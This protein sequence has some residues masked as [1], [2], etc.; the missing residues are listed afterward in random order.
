MTQTFTVTNEIYN[1]KYQT[2]VRSTS[3][4]YR[5]K[6]ELGRIFHQLADVGK[7]FFTKKEI[8][9]ILEQAYSFGGSKNP[10]AKANRVWG[11]Y[12][13]PNKDM[14]FVPAI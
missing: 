12:A 13:K 5:A 6:P 7:K 4:E 11:F 9:T 10:A 14:W 8:L 2:S 3:I 1:P